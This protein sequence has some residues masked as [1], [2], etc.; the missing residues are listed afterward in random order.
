[1]G[2]AHPTRGTTHNTHNT[3]TATTKFRYC[4]DAGHPVFEAPTRAI[5]EARIRVGSTINGLPRPFVGGYPKVWE[6]PADEAEPYN[7]PWFDRDRD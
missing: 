1:M 3:M 2:A 6:V 7:G 5:V 4:L